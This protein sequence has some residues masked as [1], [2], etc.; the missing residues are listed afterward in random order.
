MK[1]KKQENIKASGKK[2]VLK[3]G[4][5]LE[6]TVISQTQENF[7]ERNSALKISSKV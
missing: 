4:N 3:T 2:S 1:S 6:N 7:K 5:F